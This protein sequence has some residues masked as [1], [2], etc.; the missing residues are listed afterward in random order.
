MLNFT[1]QKQF[2]KYYIRTKYL[3]SVLAKGALFYISPTNI[4]T[5]FSLFFHKN[6]QL[7]PELYVLMNCR[8]SYFFAL[9]D[10]NTGMRYCKKR[11]KIIILH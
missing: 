6:I 4:Q 2:Y 11:V 7:L 10:S 5:L 1:L 9:L 3:P 8:L